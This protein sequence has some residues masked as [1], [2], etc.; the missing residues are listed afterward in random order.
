M[1]DD[2]SGTHELTSVV[3]DVPVLE[4][5]QNQTISTQ[6]N[7]ADYTSPGPRKTWL[8]NKY[9]RN[10]STYMLMPWWC[11]IPNFLHYTHQSLAI[12]KNQHY[13]SML[14]HALLLQ[15]RW[16]QN[17]SGHASSQNVTL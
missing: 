2:K 1:Q 14:Q 13:A 7:V 9:Q 8:M 3:H 4:D 6:D 10:Q 12:K 16:K 11:P 15:G 17:G 5:H